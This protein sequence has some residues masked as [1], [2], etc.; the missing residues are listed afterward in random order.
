MGVGASL[1]NHIPACRSELFL[2]QETNFCSQKIF[3]SFTGKNPPVTDIILLFLTGVI[4]T[5]T[6]SFSFDIGIFFHVTGNVLPE[7]RPL[8]RRT[9]V[10][11]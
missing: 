5:G 1:P 9:L 3:F 11:M 7:R 8:E 4:V 2:S 6:R 10:P